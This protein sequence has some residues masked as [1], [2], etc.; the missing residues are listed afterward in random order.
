MINIAKLE[1]KYISFNKFNLVF[2]SFF[3]SLMTLCVKNIDKRIPIYELVLFRSL[4]SLIITLFII[5][6]KNIN[7]WGKN[8]YY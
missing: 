8:R 1:K 3:F 6:L 5:N 2:A 7:P 4:L